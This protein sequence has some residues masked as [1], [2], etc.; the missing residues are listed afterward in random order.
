MLI[1]T[2]LALLLAVPTLALAGGAG[3]VLREEMRSIDEAERVVRGIATVDAIAEYVHALQRERGR[4]ALALGNADDSKAQS[5]LRD[6]RSETDRARHALAAAIEANAAL[7]HEQGG[8]VKEAFDALPAVLKADDALRA[9]IDGGKLKG[10]E[11]N[12]R[13]TAL[14]ADLLGHAASIAS[15]VGANEA[16]VVEGFRCIITCGRAKEFL[17][18]ERA[19]L[20]AALNAKAFAGD[21]FG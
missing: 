16:Y 7:G 11:S 9:D 4:S 2:R 20:T 6:Q 10:A 13:H 1:R 15:G 17:G 18:Q 5:A 14:L 19:T 12:V 8:R 3:F 21:G